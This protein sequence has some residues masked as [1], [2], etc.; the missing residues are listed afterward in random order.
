MNCHLRNPVVT[1][2]TSPVLADMNGKTSSIHVYVSVYYWQRFSP[3][4][5]LLQH[6]TH[7]TLHNCDNLSWRENR[8]WAVYLFNICIFL[9]NICPKIAKLLRFIKAMTIP[10]VTIYLFIFWSFSSCL[11][12]MIHTLTFSFP[13]NAESLTF[14]Q[15]YWKITLKN[16]WIHNEIEGEIP[17]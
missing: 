1:H 15:S 16:I 11:C 2:I 13:K 9:F 14:I 7:P 4:T 3:L 5:T 10:F 6:K 17:V 8:K 12:F